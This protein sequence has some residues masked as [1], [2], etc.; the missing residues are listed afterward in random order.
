MELRSCIRILSRRAA[1]IAAL[2]ALAVSALAGAVAPDAGAAKKKRKAPVITSISPKHVT[3]GETLTIRGR[4]FI[5]G[6]AKNSVIFKR[7][8]A[9]AVFVKAGIGTAKLLKVAVPRRLADQL[10]VADGAQVA[11]R[12][13]LRVLARKLGRKFTRASLSPLVS[14]ERPPVTTPPASAPEGDCDLDKL[15]NGVDGDDDN[16]LLADGVESRIKT[17]GCRSDSDGDGVTDG[18]EYQSATDLNDDEYQEPQS[19]LPAPE[20]RP[21]PNPLFADG[22]T[23]YDGDSLTLGQEFALWKAYRNPAAGLADLV[24]SDGNQYSAYRRNAS[25]RR[26]GDLVGAD[27]HAKYADFFGW[28]S[29]AGYAG[30][31]LPRG[32]SVTGLYE[33]AGFFELRDFDQTGGALSVRED[34]YYDFDLDGKLSDDERDEDA[35]GLTNFDESTGRLLAGYWAGCYTSDKP[36]PITYA[37]NRPRRP[38]QRRRRRARRRRRPG[39]RRPAELDGAEP[40]GR[41]CEL[42]VAG[43]RLR[44]GHGRCRSHA[45]ARPREPVQPVPAVRR[46]AHLRAAPE[47]RQPLRAVRSGRPELPDPELARPSTLQPGARLH[48]G[49]RS[50]TRG[51]P[52]DVRPGQASVRDADTRRVRLPRRLQDQSGF[53]LV[54]LLVAMP[55]ALLVLSMAMLAVTTAVRGELSSREHSEA[56]RAQQVGLERITREL[57]EATSFSFLD[58]QRVE[59]NAWSRAASG[60]RKVRFDCSSGTDCIR[61]EGPVGGTVSGSRVVIDALENPDVFEP[62]PDFIN[63]RYVAVVAQV[64]IADDRRLITLRDGVE[65]RNLGSRF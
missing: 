26:P 58:S 60:L 61:Q 21:Y 23:D 65:L 57:R 11:T 55:I 19:I 46:L 8:G 44:Q 1:F 5:K 32:H 6:R 31:W 18:Y 34:R 28:T 45:G 2:G 35:D 38:R 64:R 9:R 63:P 16:D 49:L 43:R 17:D 3:I 37:G 30:V 39:P 12:F 29:A 40:A 41:R 56:L 53:T 7:A 48:G 33:P 20:K 25:G 52:A 4:H 13:R 51:R 24:Y 59:F 42:Q 22:G 50:L 27:P 54:E 10:L 36:F 14:P 15:L 47:L 62:A